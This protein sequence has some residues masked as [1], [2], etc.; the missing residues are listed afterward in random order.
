MS[1]REQFLYDL[2]SGNPPAFGPASIAR[3]NTLPQYAREAAEQ[4]YAAYQQAAQRA[5][6]AQQPSQPPVIQQLMGID[7]LP[8]NLPAQGYAP[9]GIVAFDDGGEV[10]R[11]QTGGS[12]P[13]GRWW[14]SVSPWSPDKQEAAEIRRR[15]QQRYG[16]ASAP[17]GGLFVPQTDVERQR[18][19]DIM[20]RIRS[21]SLEELREFERTN[22]LPPAYSAATPPM[23][24]PETVPAPKADLKAPPPASAPQLGGGFQIPSSA[25]ALSEKALG[26]DTPPPTFTY[27][28]PSMETAA[29]EMF[30][31]KEGTPGLIADVEKVRGE[32][33][34]QREEA[35]KKVT[36]K[37]FEGYE[38]DIRKDA[39]QI[40][41]Q[42]ETHPYMDLIKAGLGMI[43]ASAPGKTA[44]QAISEGGMRGIESYEATSK[45]LQKAARENRK[46]LANIEQARRAEAVGDRDKQI[47]RI[48]AAEHNAVSMLSSIA[49]AIHKATGADRQLAFDVA[50][51]NYAASRDW[52]ITFLKTKVDIANILSR[53]GTARAELGQRGA[54]AASQLDLTR[55]RYSLLDAASKY[56]M[57]EVERKAALDWEGSEEKRKALEAAKTMPPLQA[58]HHIKTARAA[59]MAGIPS[60]GSGL[61]G[62][63]VPRDDE[64]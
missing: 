45:D 56:R 33:E 5:Q 51:T 44:A 6:A 15:I 22:V 41:A 3:M 7:N 60:L 23:P 4:Q 37:A 26:L 53:E 17:L 16:V 30:Y 38:S 21:M 40:A 64:L 52:A 8:S 13:I 62:A 35:R 43:A 31:G 11:F 46:E 54:I 27:A 18:A 10:K 12:T 34:K 2:F 19:K 25:A 50:K 20:S 9:G 36:G 47:T 39:E 32:K 63:R 49:E 61:G 59:Y 14:E 42:K 57:A 24:Q 29:R 55:Q 28:G 58:E 48:D 1:I